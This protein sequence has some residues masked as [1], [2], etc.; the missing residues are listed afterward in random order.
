M[1]VSHLVF[2]CKHCLEQFEDSD[3]A[4]TL[5]PETRVSRPEADMYVMKFCSRNHLQ[6]FL[7]RLSFQ[8]QLYILTKNGRT[9]AKQFEAAK[10]LD[11]L[12]LV[13]SAKAS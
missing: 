11:L 4:Y 13:G 9:G 3:L 6:E 7:Q 5:I 1:E 8:E 2:M 12:L 10:P